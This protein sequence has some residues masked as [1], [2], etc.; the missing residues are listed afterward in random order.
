MLAD[1]DKFILVQKINNK[2]QNSENKLT[3]V[4]FTEIQKVIAI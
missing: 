2:L 1:R 3:K 4:T